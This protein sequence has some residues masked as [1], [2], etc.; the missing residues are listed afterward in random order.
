MP[1]VKYLMFTRWCEKYFALGFIINERNNYMV[2]VIIP[3]Y[4]AEKY[5][6]KCI[7]SVL[8]QKYKNIEIIAVNDGSTD[9]SWSILQKYEKEH[10]NVFK[11]F[12]QENS[13][14]SIARNLALQQAQGTYIAFLDSDDYL[15]DDYFEKLV[16]VAEKNNSDMVCS[17]EIR[18]TEEGKIV[19]KIRYK[20]DKNGNCCLRRLN[21]SGKI[22]RKDF[23][24]KHN[25][26]FAEGKVY[27]D[28]PF[29]IMAFALAQN[30]KIIDYMGYYQTVH[31]G[32]TTTKNIYV[33]RLPFDKIEEVIQ[34]IIEH[35]NLVEDFDLFEY[36]VFSFFTYFL[37]KAN[38]Q[39]YY[40]D[41]D[42][43]KSS[44]EVVF[45]ICE[46]CET[47][48]KKYFPDYLKCRYIWALKR[49]GVSITQKLGVYVFL[50]LNKKECLQKFVKVYYK[51]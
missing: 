15:L 28:N 10:P 13:G 27:E 1:N 40:F 21:F 25:I 11:I 47:I 19:S 34:Y 18:I 17:G 6:D 51:Y 3:V 39:H 35:K 46:Y 43:R 8:R 36:T 48:I 9:N 22:Y 23:L 44:S 26:R 2:S 12:T 30:L 4:N 50:Q 33:D 24:E 38:K 20:T 16:D 41:I 32:S 49:N 37:F 45:Q 5:L 31:Q 42:G 7:T 29:N 14:Q